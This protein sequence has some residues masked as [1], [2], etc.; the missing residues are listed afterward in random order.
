[1]KKC[2]EAHMERPLPVRRMLN[3]AKVMLPDIVNMVAVLLYLNPP[4][5]FWGDEREKSN[6]IECFN[7]LHWARRHDD[8]GKLVADAL[9]GNFFERRGVFYY[10][11]LGRGVYRE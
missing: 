9:R 4:R 3:R 7:A 8:A 11:L 1:M 2:R 5:R 10:R 6:G